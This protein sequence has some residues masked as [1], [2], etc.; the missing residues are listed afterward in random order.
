MRKHFSGKIFVLTT[1]CFCLIAAAAGYA[2][3]SLSAESADLQYELISKSGDPHMA[4]G[5]R[6]EWDYYICDGSAPRQHINHSVLNYQNGTAGIQSE[7]MNTGIGREELLE[8]ST[9]QYGQSASLTVHINATS[10]LDGIMLRYKETD[11]PAIPFTDYY[12]EYDLTWYLT[13]PGIGRAY[14]TSKRDG[15]DPVFQS[16]FRIPV[17]EKHYLTGTSDEETDAVFYDPSPYCTGGEEAVY[18]CLRNDYYGSTYSPDRRFMDMS[19]LSEGFG[20]YVFPYRINPEEKE[21][22]FDG[23]E[24]ESSD[25]YRLCRLPE[26]SII[27]GMRL[28]G[29]ETVLFLMTEERNRVLLSVIDAKTGEFLSVI[30]VGETEVYHFLMGEKQGGDF[31]VVCAGNR[32][33][34]I[35]KT[36]EGRWE[37]TFQMPLERIDE[38]KRT[39]PSSD[40]WRHNMIYRW[41]NEQM[42]VFAYDGRRLAV[43]I[44]CGNKN[45]R[46]QLMILTEEGIQYEETRALTL[47]NATSNDDSYTC[48]AVARAAWE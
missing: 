9:K 32:L 15:I 27:G 12:D 22:R 47:K 46:F 2:C 29:D 23:V 11:P 30:D 7:R 19:R 16:L 17:L 45:D 36:A 28:S 8:Y 44:V 39:Y 33:H 21:D 40:L 26:D 31:C 24:A 35:A 18:F 48:N 20:I 10:A 6:M 37:D 34:V 14:D 1:V 42:A 41:M 5:L 25:I 43:I 3:K 4:D 13:I 38:V